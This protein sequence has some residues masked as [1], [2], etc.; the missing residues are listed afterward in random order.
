MTDAEKQKLN[1]KLARW[2][3]FIEADIRKRYYFAIGG[4]RRAKWYRP[5]S[6]YSDRL[7]NF[8]NSLDACFKWLVTKAIDEGYDIGI[9]VNERIVVSR[10]EKPEFYTEELADGISITPLALCL[11]IEKLI[12]AGDSRSVD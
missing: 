4:E 10:F 1:E 8:T 2:A 7:P 9:F 12:K 6:E 11:A 3:G 5:D